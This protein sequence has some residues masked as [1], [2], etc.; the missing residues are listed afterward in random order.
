MGFKCPIC[1]KDFK[2]DNKAM[3]EHT[4]VSH[5]GIGNDFIKVIEN[6]TIE[7]SPKRRRMKND[8]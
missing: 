4:K 6:M 1:L 8:N 5:G 2:Y 3:L 7:N